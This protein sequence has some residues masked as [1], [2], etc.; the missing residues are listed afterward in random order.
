M[1]KTNQEKRIEELYG[2]INV[3]VHALE[4][5]TETMEVMSETITG[6]TDL[7]RTLIEGMASKSQD[8]DE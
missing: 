5:M 7:L 1:T 8:T 3:I 6:L 4:H 2:E